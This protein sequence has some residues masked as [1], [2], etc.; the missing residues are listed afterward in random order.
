M[1][2]T[3]VRNPLGDQI[4]DQL[5][6]DII[7]GRFEDGAHLAEESLA[8]RYGVSRGP[9]REAL[10]ALAAEG[11]VASV[12]GR[13]YVRALGPHDVRELYSLRT[14]IEALALRGAA[15][16]PG[17]LDALGSAVAE[18]AVAGAAGDE[19]R[20]ADA[21]LEF[22]SVLYRLSGNGRLLDTW[23]R[24]APTFGVLLRLSNMPDP[25]SAVADH[26]RI[27]EFIRS[28]PLDDAVAEL[29][30]HIRRGEVIIHHR[31]LALT[32]AEHADP[33]PSA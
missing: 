3:L 29:G 5:R 25:A 27:I 4:S 23:E 1:E 30:A 26:E 7:T 12:R 19:G 18:M 2:S 32:S 11:L 20:M 15:A 33:R 10:R 28:R 16:D 8:A 22:H 14:T 21:D 9:V 13:I 6:W 24:Y 17:L 31:V